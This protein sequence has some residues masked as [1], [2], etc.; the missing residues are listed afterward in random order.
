MKNIKDV[1]NFIINE[2]AGKADKLRKYDKRTKL[3]KN[4]E[5]NNIFLHVRKQDGCLYL[6]VADL[7]T[8]LQFY[9]QEDGAN[10]SIYAV[11]ECLENTTPVKR[12]V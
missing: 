7:G 12:I 3:I 9:F 5:K 2:S 8:Y 4:L 11:V 10:V 6:Y 1:V